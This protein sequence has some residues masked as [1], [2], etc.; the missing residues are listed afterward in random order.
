MPAKRTGSDSKVQRDAEATV[1][2]QVNRRLGIDLVGRSLSL[3]GC[4]VDVDGYYETDGTITIIEVWSHIGPAKS[5]QRNKVLTDVLKLALIS[6]HLQDQKPDAVI[7]AYVIFIDKDAEKVLTNKSWGATAAQT[8]GVKSIVV[9][10]P[11]DLVHAVKKHR[12]TRI[13]AKFCRT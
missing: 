10:I 2:E 4:S 3:P 7:N 9:E 8:F 13:Y 5:A 11:Q 6:K 12:S 1:I